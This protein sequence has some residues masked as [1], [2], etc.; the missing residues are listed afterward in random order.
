MDKLEIRVEGEK[1]FL[2][3]LSKLSR[4]VAPDKMEPILMGG[5]KIITAASK[6]NAPKDTGGLRKAIRTKKL[7]RMFGHAAPAASVVDRKRAPHAF[8]VHEGTGERIGGPRSKRYRGFHFGRMPKNPFHQKAWDENKG[9][10]QDYITKEIEKKL[11]R[12]LT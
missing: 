5:A 6:A 1:E 4:S 12:S 7:K 11:G 10:V 9:K 3:A 8:W 2:D